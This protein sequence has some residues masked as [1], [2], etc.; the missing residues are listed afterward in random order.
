V[1][2]QPAS[3]FWRFQAIETAIYLTLAGAL[4]ATA[5]WWIQRRVD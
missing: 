2:Y 4:I 3:R 5:I 1:I